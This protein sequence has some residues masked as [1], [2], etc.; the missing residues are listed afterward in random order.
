MFYT[1]NPKEADYKIFVSQKEYDANW[2]VL[3]T[4]W[5]KSVKKGIWFE[6]K[7]KNEA[8]L[9]VYIVKEKYLADKI[10]F[11]TEF[12]SKIKF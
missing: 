1:S 5:I 12:E 3:K 4:N 9:V 7:Y 10:V 2:I 11:F 6:V 8:D